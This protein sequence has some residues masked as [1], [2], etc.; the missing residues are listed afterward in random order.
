[1]PSRPA[2]ARPIANGDRALPFTNAVG[3]ITRMG[4]GAVGMVISTVTEATSRVTPDSA[5]ATH[6][7]TRRP[8][9]SSGMLRLLPGALLGAGFEAERRILNASAAL[10]TR[11]IRASAALSRRVPGAPRSAVERSLVQW[12]ERGRAE[13]ARNELVMAEFVRR[14]APELAEAI[15]VRLPLEEIVSRVDMAT[16][17]RRLLESIDLAGIVRESTATV[18]SE[19]VDAGRTQAM[20]VDSLVERMVDRMLFRREPRQVE[21]EE[22]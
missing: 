17:T 8:E 10:E 2:D 12:S 21:V 6:G 13:Q 11:L 7:A 15:V 9:S 19:V 14:L 22:T 16:L 1:M 4:L 20:S 18:G 5:A 3:G